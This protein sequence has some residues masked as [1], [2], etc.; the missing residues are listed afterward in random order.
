MSF[1]GIPNFNDPCAQINERVH[2]SS[3]AK[4]VEVLYG[5]KNSDGTPKYPVKGDGHGHFVAL[6][7]DGIYQMIM[8]RHPDSEGGYQEYGDY[9]GCKAD[10]KHNPLQDLEDD[11]KEKKD[12]LRKARQMMKD[13]N[14]S[15]SSVD[16][17][18]T[19]FD[20]IFDMNTPVEQNLKQQYNEIVEKNNRNKKYIQE[21]ERNAEQKRI[22]ISQAQSLQNS[23]E[24]KSTSA[25]MKELM[26]CWKQIGSAGKD[27]D[28]RLWSEFQ[29]IRNDFY[30]RRKTASE[31]RANELLARRQAKAALIS[32]AQAYVRS[33]DY[34]ASSADRMR[35]MHE[36]WKSIGFCGNEYDDQL[37]SQFRMAQDT[38][39]R[40]K[41]SNGEEKHRVWVAKTQE[42][43]CRRKNRINNI[44]RN[45][46]NLK[47]RLNTTYNYDKQN[48]IEGW[49]SEDEAKIRELEEEIYNMEMELG[50]GF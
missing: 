48:Q 42:A 31:K 18:L 17:I 5:A 43:I 8:W 4:I 36:E 26:D 41:K 40:G 49:I 3:G 24:W 16:D 1:Y 10:R 28:D 33:C 34:N 6:E 38:Y 12:L 37:W 7:I 45:I 25:K 50:R 23:E 19:R 11:I 44:Q 14:Y 22:L 35:R 13:K 2:S 20:C 9:E 39:W 27:E 21:Q 46:D 15:T 29:N 32:E 47:E 30:A